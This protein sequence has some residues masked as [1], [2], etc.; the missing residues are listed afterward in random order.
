MGST[1]S[2]SNYSSYRSKRGAGLIAFGALTALAAGAGIACT[3]WSMFGS[4]GGSSHSQEGIGYALQELEENKYGW[5]EVNS[6]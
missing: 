1:T 3:L 5:T 6:K 2:V 4:C